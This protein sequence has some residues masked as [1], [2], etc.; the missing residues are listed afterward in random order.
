MIASFSSFHNQSVSAP[1]DQATQGLRTLRQIDGTPGDKNPNPGA[2]SMKTSQGQLDAVVLSNP[3]KSQTV[4]Q[5]LTKNSGEVL[6]SWL[7]I[8]QKGNGIPNMS[9]FEVSASLIGLQGV[10]LGVRENWG[11]TMGIPT[12]TYET[13]LLAKNE[14]QNSLMRAEAVLASWQFR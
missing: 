12:R 8:P 11:G 6:T 14:S 4:V 1:Y 2:I 9:G 10:A 3:D 7:E 5:R 13:Q